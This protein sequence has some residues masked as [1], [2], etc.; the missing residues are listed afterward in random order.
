MK[1]YPSIPRSTGQSFR[2]FQAYVFDK[3]DGSNLRAEWTR[4]RGWDKFGTRE[5]LF[6]KTDPDFGEAIEIFKDTLASDVETVAK[7]QR[8]DQLTVFMEFWGDKSFAGQHV[9]G[10]PKRLTLFDANPY[11]KGILGPKE[12]LDLFGF[13]GYCTYRSP[14]FLGRFNWTRGFVEEIRTGK[15]PAG[16]TFEGVV[17]KAGEGHKL[18]MA[19]AKTQAWIDKVMERYGIESGKKIIDS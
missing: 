6:D 18:V 10:D 16:I 13:L 15:G 3:L 14:R 17:G 8:W 4:K 12:F 11:K 9:K 2:E 5:R 1:H 7:N 19:K